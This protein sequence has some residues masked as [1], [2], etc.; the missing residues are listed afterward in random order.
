MFVG[1]DFSPLRGGFIKSP[2]P[3]VAGEYPPQ[4]AQRKTSLDLKERAMP[5]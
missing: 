2:D 1:L 4:S 3:Q 5:V